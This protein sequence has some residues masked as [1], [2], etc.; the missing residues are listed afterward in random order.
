MESNSSISFIYF[1]YFQ[2][3][4]KIKTQQINL[5]TTKIQILHEEGDRNYNVLVANIYH[6]RLPGYLSFIPFKKTFTIARVHQ[7]I[8][9]DDESYL[10]FKSV[11]YPFGSVKPKIPDVVDNISQAGYKIKKIDQKSCHVSFSFELNQDMQFPPDVFLDSLYTRSVAFNY[12]LGLREFFTHST[13]HEIGKKISKDRKQPIEPEVTSITFV[14][15]FILFI[16]NFLMKYS[17]IL[18]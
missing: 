14:I 4:K 16:S 2:K 18:L 11:H 5:T 12:A 15:Y 9:E 17:H 6:K 7:R 3:K 13:Q 8:V 10:F 1:I